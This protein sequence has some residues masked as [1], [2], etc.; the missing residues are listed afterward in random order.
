MANFQPVTE[1]MTQ[2]MNY[3]FSGHMSQNEISSNKQKPGDKFLPKR[4]QAGYM[5]KRIEDQENPKE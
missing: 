1:T 3:T 4:G 2:H 5:Q